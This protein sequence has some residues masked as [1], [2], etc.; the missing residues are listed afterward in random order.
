MRALAVAVAVAVAAGCFDPSFDHP[1]CGPGGA[2]PEGWTCVVD[3][4]EVYDAPATDAVR[5]DAPAD[6]AAACDGQGGC[7]AG[8]L[9]VE[10]TCVPAPVD[11]AVDGQACGPAG[12]CPSGQVCVDDLCR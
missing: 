2:C 8:Q 7:P 5:T 1:R 12:E 10:R 4:C 11:A 3:R 6:G 9:C